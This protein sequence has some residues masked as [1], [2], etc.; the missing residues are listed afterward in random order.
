MLVC[1]DQRNG[2]G[3]GHENP[4]GAAQ[5]QQCGRPLRYALHLLNPGARVGRYRVL[6]LIGC[7]GFGAVY[8]VQ[9][10]GHSH[11][12]ALKETLDAQML[13][14]F[15]REFAVLRRLRHPHLPQYYEMF[16]V[17][18]NGYLAMEF[19]P[20]QSLE[21][22]RRRQ[23]GPLLEGQ[24]LGYALQLCDV[25]AYLHGQQPPLLHRDIKPA[26]IRFTPEG[27]IKLVDF[28]LFK[29]GEG[30]TQRS[31]LGL[32]PRYAPLE[33]YSASGQTDR[34]SDLYSLGATLY[35]LL[36]GREPATAT[37]RIAVS[38][39]PLPR[40]RAVNPALSASVDAALW[41]AL[42]IKKDDRFADAGQFKRALIGGAPVA[43]RLL[44]P[45]ASA[46]QRPAQT[47]SVERFI[48]RTYGYWLAG[49]MGVL[50]LLGGLLLV[51]SGGQRAATI[52]LPAT[53]GTA[54]PAP[55]TAINPQNAAQ[56][57][58]LAR[59]GK[60]TVNQVVYSPDGVL[61]AG[62]SSLGIY[63]Y[64]AETLEEVRWIETDAR[65]NRVAFSPDGATLASGSEDK[66]VRFWRVSDGA[67]LHTLE[68]H[69]DSV[70]RVA[71]S[72]DGVTLASG[73]EDKTVRFWR[74]SDGALLHTL[75]GHTES[76]SSVAFSPD[77]VTLASGAR[78]NT[79]RLWRVS[80]GALLHTLEG[81]TSSVSSVAFS[82]DGRT[83]ASGAWDNVRLW[84]VSDGALLHTLEGYTASV[85]SV[86]FSPDGVTLASGSSEDDTV[87]IDR[88]SVV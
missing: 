11:I 1:L 53:M 44:P 13:R 23:N 60:G 67:L 46:P 34:R 41:R 74:V 8:R 42:A 33:Q 10:Q 18:G 56:V 40:P 87:R 62:A 51:R 38:A 77:E 54:V 20:G 30:L 58:Q 57:T 39:D 43:N 47:T 61:L 2:S 14:S 45:H 55:R 48:R 50:L 22:I 70:N 66:T 79:V 64:D 9:V 6:D 21:D 73:S 72:P 68:G 86:A 69:T 15:A 26:N 31:R 3:C 16:E 49:V 36:T 35:H 78:D 4:D 80:D 71:F 76:V 85:S 27:V 81:H 5:C 28:G 25:L 17:G 83:L 75:E 52:A 19:V 65:V 84:R 88:K 37:D 63:L 7:G 82:P 12:V 59:W 24:V 32:T 29:V